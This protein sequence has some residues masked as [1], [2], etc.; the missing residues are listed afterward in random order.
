MIRTD[1]KSRKYPYEVGDFCG[2]WE[3]KELELNFGYCRW[4]NYKYRTNVTF[5]IE[6]N[7][8]YQR[9][10]LCPDIG[11][12]LGELTIA[13]YRNTL[14]TWAIDYLFS[15]EDA[16]DECMDFSND[17]II[18]QWYSKIRDKFPIQRHRDK[19][20]I[21]E[22]LRFILGEFATDEIDRQEV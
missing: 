4:S 17:S 14:A 11:G 3:L 16:L 5:D 22:G 19:V 12:L 21:R 8:H 10:I 6:K 2:D 7:G 20:M 13:D 9:A 15:P 18:Q 1:M